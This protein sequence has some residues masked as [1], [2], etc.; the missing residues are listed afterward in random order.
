MS[1]DQAGLYKS[2]WLRED[3]IAYV[4]LIGIYDERLVEEVNTYMCKELLEKGQAPVHI[5]LDASQLTGYPRNIRV[6]K[7]ASETTA[8]HPDLGWLLL[9]GFDNP[10]VKFFSTVL[11]QMF[12]LRFKQV[13][14]VEEAVTTIERVDLSLKKIS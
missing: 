1:T 6:L 12:K 3:R 4:E 14:T 5:I 10:V 7:K 11:V 13:G 8:S 2:S 9:V